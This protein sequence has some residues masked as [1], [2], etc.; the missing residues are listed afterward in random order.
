MQPSQGVN[1][2]MR[3]NPNPLG[4][5]ET[6]FRGINRVFFNILN[7][8]IAGP[9]SHSRSM[10]VYEKKNLLRRYRGGNMHHVK[11]KCSEIRPSNSKNEYEDKTLWK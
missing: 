6:H 11:R 4:I 8:R 10:L 2:T 9:C 3:R 5:T 1:Y 7:I